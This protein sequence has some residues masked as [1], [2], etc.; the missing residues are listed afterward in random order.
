MQPLLSGAIVVWLLAA[1]QLRLMIAKHPL[2]IDQFLRMKVPAVQASIGH[3]TPPIKRA[4]RR[5]S[6]RRDIYLII[7]ED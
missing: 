1:A 7:P 5:L 3:T 2:L 4:L 6:C